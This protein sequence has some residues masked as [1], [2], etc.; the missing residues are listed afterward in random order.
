MD[1][2]GTN[3]D[4]FVMAKYSLIKATPSTNAYSCI[5]EMMR[6]EMPRGKHRILP[7]QVFL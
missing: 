3:S 6:E 4:M 7:L 5:Q 2:A 1:D